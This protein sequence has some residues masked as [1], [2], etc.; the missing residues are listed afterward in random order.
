[1]NVSLF[2]K[3]E[4]EV[5]MAMEEIPMAV[6]LIMNFPGG[7]QEQ[8]EA[9]LEQLNLRGRMPPGGI[10]HAAGP[11]DGGWRVVDVWESQEAFDA[12]LHEKL[13]QAM[14]SAGMPRP[15]VESWPVYATLE[16]AI[17]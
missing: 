5:S 15:E 6:G 8:Y 10:S 12:F 1:V 13:Y 3:R 17:P 11:I 14:Q 9:V 16:P 2:H 7:T 4:E